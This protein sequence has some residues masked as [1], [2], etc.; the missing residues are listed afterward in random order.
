VV[1]ADWVGN[2]DALNTAG[3]DIFHGLDS[4]LLAN[5]TE[6]TVPHEVSVW[7]PMTAV[8]PAAVAN[9]RPLT[10]V[11][12]GGYFAR[13]VNVSCQPLQSIMSVCGAS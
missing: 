9:A 10:E 3:D 8:V 7:L 12:D 2:N 11:N 1:D 5:D 13:G 6:A 4:P